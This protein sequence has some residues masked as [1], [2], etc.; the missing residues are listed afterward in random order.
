[1]KEC[2][3][4]IIKPEAISNKSIGTIISMIENSNLTIEEMEM[5]SASEEIITKHYYKEDHFVSAIG[6]NIL[7]AFIDAG[8]DPIREIGTNDPLGAGRVLT[9]WVIEHIISSPIIIMKI[10]GVDAIQRFRKLCGHTFPA[11]A[12]PDSIRGRLGDDDNN[13]STLAKRPVLNFIHSSGDKDEAE[14]E[15]NLWFK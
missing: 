2:T 13:K 14:F 1:M 11:M 12:S 10:S 6:E 15:L 3:F 7:K 8:K 4:G 9:R 5:I